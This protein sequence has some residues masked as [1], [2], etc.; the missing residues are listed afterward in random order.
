MLMQSLKILITIILN[1]ELQMDQ[2]FAPTK[3]VL[4]SSK[5]EWNHKQYILVFSEIKQTITIYLKH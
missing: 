4:I 5:K 3:L 2:H 1:S